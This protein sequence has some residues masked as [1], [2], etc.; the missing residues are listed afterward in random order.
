[1]KKKF[2]KL[3]KIYKWDVRMRVYSRRNNGSIKYVTQ[4]QPLW[5]P[6]NATVE[7]MEGESC[8]QL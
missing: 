3:L 4:F 6:S 1:M 5:N 2:Y 7:Y 8:I